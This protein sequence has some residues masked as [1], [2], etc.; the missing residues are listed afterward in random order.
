MSGDDSCFK[1]MTLAV[2]LKKD[3]RY[4]DRN[5][6]IN[7][8]STEVNSD[9]ST[10]SEQVKNLLSRYQKETTGFPDEFDNIK[11]LPTSKPS[12]MSGLINLH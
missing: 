9:V 12:D 11:H 8:E 6:E 2:I 10:S 4:K 1:Q 5:R 7:A 3:Q